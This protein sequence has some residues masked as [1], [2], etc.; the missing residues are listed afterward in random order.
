MPKVVGQDPSVVKRV[1]CK[2]CGAIN[3]YLPNEVRELY[4]GR[5]IT[6]CG[7]GHDGF[8][9]ANCGKEIITRSW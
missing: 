5:D 2:H 3:E 8:N 9:C 6:G 1:T 7:E 4:R